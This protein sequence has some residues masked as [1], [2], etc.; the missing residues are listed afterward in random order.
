MKVAKAL[1]E[2][3]K[4]KESVYKET[5]EMDKK[6]VIRYFKE[7]VDRFLDQMGYKKIKVSSVA[8]RLDKK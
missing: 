1:E 2:V 5:K 8:Y 4:W 7:G 6:E 3:W